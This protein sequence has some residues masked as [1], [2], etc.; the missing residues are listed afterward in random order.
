MPDPWA[1]PI[2][3]HSFPR[4]WT[5][6]PPCPS[7]PLFLLHV[8]PMSVKSGRRV[9][10]LGLRTCKD[11][12]NLLPVCT[13][14]LALCGVFVNA[15]R[16][17]LHWP[18]VQ[19]SQESLRGP[20]ALQKLKFPQRRGSWAALVWHSFLQVLHLP[21]IWVGTTMASAGKVGGG[22]PRPESWCLQSLAT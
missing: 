1:A 18:G 11:S 19:Q 9:L 3:S 10:E 8:L 15:V 22:V 14:A 4:S 16:C 5:D 6:P 2:L 21:V 13:K 17:T 12:G 7:S 20:C